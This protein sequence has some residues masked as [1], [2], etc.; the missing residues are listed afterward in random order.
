MPDKHALLGPSGA[1]R[2]MACTPSARLEEGTPNKSTVYTEEGTLAHRIGELNL[3]ATFERA[4]ITSDVAAAVQDPL[5]D[6]SMAGY[7]ADYADYVL[8][9]MD[10]ACKRC[11]DPA[12]FIEHQIDATDYIPEGFGTADCVI[13]ADGVMDVV[14]FKYG[15]GVAVDAERNPQMMIYG[16]GCLSAFDCIYDIDTVRMTVYQPRIDNVSTFTMPAADLREWGETVLKPRA[17]LAWAGE[18]EYAPSPETCKWCKARARCRALA[19]YE[20]SQIKRDFDEPALLAPAE[21]AEVLAAGAGFVEW[22][23]A[24]K[25]YALDAAENHGEKF[26]GWKLVEGRSNRVYTDEKAVAKALKA[27]GYAAADIYKPRTLRGLTELER[28]IGKRQLAEII[29]DFITKPAGKPT[30]VPA[31]DKRPEIGSAARAAE[32]FA[33]DP[34][35]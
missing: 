12:I 35:V 17:A 28:Q 2:W 33:D 5:Y 29:G 3:R 34:I 10:D 27:M 26:P 7:V 22:Y 20:M 24:V 31:S 23:N 1:A 25:D 18:G 21:V 4:D 14:D 11:A 8:G 15:R 19:D 9:L 13:I 6:Q 30:L 16:L 32:D